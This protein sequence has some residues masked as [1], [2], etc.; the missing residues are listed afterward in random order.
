MNK[1]K[2]FYICSILFYIVAAIGGYAMYKDNKSKNDMQKGFIAYKKGDYHNAFRAFINQ[3]LIYNPEASFIIGAMYF[4]GQ[5]VAPDRARA[6]QYY[7]KAALMDYAPAM[8]TLAFLYSQEGKYDLAEPHAI[9]AAEKGDIESQML[10]AAWY[11]NGSLPVNY[12]KAEHYYELAAKK[13]DF[14]AK[15]NLAM[16]YRYGRLGVRPN[17][18][19]AMRLQGEMFKMQKIKNKLRASR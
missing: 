5:G 8:T 2:L 1:R 13:G 19:K 4:A 14:T 9:R 11:E 15:N 18:A 10:L 6:I 3:D 17:L 16:Y 7:E 12:K